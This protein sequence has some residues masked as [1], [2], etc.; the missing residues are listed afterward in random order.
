MGTSLAI[1]WRGLAC[2]ELNR[3][4]QAVDIF[5]KMREDFGYTFE[6]ADYLS[7]AL[8][9]LKRGKEVACLARDLKEKDDSSPET[10][11]C[12]G[13]CLSLERHQLHAIEALQR[14]VE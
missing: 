4:E 10:W 13:N 2:Y 5:Y 8:W 3:F 11:I 6:G 12:I 1:K 7:S 14:C 9:H